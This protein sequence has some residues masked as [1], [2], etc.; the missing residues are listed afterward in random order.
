VILGFLG[1]TSAQNF[2]MASILSK[3][4]TMKGSTLR[5]RYDVIVVIITVNKSNE[6]CEQEQ[7]I[8]I[9]AEQGVYRVGDA[10]LRVQAAE[11]SY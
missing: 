6:T 10:A 1:G 5:S 11:A 7:A 2:N 9:R 4:L 3:R 8:Q